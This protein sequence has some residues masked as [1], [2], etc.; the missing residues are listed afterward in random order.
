L[1]VGVFFPK[2]KRGSNFETLAGHGFPLVLMP[3]S[4]PGNRPEL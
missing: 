3:D 4:G 2:K 1:K